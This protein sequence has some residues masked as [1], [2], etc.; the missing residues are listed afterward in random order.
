MRYYTVDLQK[1]QID[2]S[3]KKVLLEII[4][5]K[6]EYLPMGISINKEISKEL[7]GKELDSI[8]K[9]LKTRWVLPHGIN[10]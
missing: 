9:K 3:K 7:Q 10:L 5:Q 2:R 8:D 4:L 1:E 6:E